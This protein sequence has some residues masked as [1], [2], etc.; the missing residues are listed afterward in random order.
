MDLLHCCRGPIDS[1]SPAVV[2][3]VLLG[4]LFVP[5]CALPKHP[6]MHGHE[7]LRGTVC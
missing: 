3:P 2:D 7:L 6:Y 4:L 1:V 5:R